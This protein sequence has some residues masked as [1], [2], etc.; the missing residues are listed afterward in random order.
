MTRRTLLIH[1]TEPTM[2]QE[3]LADLP[4]CRDLHPHPH[5]PKSGIKFNEFFYKSFLTIFN[6]DKAPGV[7]G[8]FDTQQNLWHLF[9]HNLKIMKV[10]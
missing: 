6:I 9:T 5:P 8:T 3:E 7:C 1:P 4:V 2:V 10:M